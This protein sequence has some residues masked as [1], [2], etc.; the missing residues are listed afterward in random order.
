MFDLTIDLGRDVGLEQVSLSDQ[1]LDL[2][3]GGGLLCLHAFAACLFSHPLDLGRGASVFG[4]LGGRDLGGDAAG[5]RLVGPPAVAGGTFG[6]NGC[7][8]G[9]G[10]EISF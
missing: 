4:A 8:N 9:S 5:L 2:G 1:R 6:H 10:Q 7:Q 3:G